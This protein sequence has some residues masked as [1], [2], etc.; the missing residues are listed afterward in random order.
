MD[1]ADN[2][3]LLRFAQRRSPEESGATAA[4]PATVPPP[5]QCAINTDTP[6]RRYHHSPGE[7][8]PVAGDAQNRRRVLPNV[9]RAFIP[10]IL[11]FFIPRDEK[12]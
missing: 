6:R 10:A 9:P 12:R 7:L 3:L 4:Q 11:S 8:A 2:I 5:M 1:N